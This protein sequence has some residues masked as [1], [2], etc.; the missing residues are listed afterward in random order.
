MSQIVRTASAEAS[1]PVPAGDRCGG[2]AHLYRAAGHQAGLPQHRAYRRHAGAVLRDRS[3]RCS[4]R[5][6]ASPC[7]RSV[8]RPRG[9]RTSPPRDAGRGSLRQRRDRE[10]LL[11]GNRGIAQPTVRRGSDRG[12]RRHTALRQRDGRSQSGRAAPAPLS[13]FMSTTPSRVGRSASPTF[14]ERTRRTG[15]RRAGRISSRS[16]SGARYRARY[17]ALRWRLPMRPPSQ[18]RNS[19]P[20]TRSSPTGSARSINSPM[21]RRSA[22]TTR[23]K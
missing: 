6:H 1:P 14:L 22:G 3:D 12:F 5:R 19:S 4:D 11:P 17:G 8:G 21:R 23:R 9:F 10:P 15:F 16:M 13:G 2:A 7:R 18:P 20:P